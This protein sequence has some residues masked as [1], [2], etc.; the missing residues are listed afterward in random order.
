MDDEGVPMTIRRIEH[1]PEILAATPRRLNQ[2][3]AAHPQMDDEGVP[4]TIRRIEHQPEIL[5]AT[6]RGL[7]QVAAQAIC[8][9]N[10]PRLMTAGDP[11]AD[12]TGR[13]D[14]AT[15]DVGIESATDDLYLG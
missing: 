8:Q 13:L 3:L 2:E 14:A 11:G 5:A 6:P 9:I 4:M 12:E 15:D 10:R 7:N 1:Q